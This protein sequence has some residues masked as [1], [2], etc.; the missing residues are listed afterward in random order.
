MNLGLLLFFDFQKAKGLTQ[1]GLFGLNSYNSLYKHILNV[2]DINFTNYNRQSITKTAIVLHHSASPDNA[3]NMFSIWQNDNWGAVATSIGI[4]RSG[5]IVRG[6]D[7]SFWGWH[8]AGSQFDASFVACEVMNW[9]WLTER[10]GKFYNYTG[11]E[12]SKEQV[13]EVNF[14]GIKY[15]HKYS[16]EQIKS[17]KYWILLNA[18]RF[19]I[20]LQYNHKDLWELCHDAQMNRRMGI[21]THNS[22]RL[23]KSDISPQM[24]MVEMLKSLWFYELKDKKAL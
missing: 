11:N 16:K 21:F 5:K 20:P 6:F 17:L 12:V 3:K 13:E 19:D 15:F 18:L 2:E 8:T 9:G 24:E 1:D 23:D 22:F 7:E 4:E 14:R 10:E